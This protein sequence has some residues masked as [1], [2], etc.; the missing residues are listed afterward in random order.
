MPS[1]DRTIFALLLENALLK[2]KG[3]AFEDFF[4][5]A[6]TTLWE[7]DFSPWRSQG[8]I[9][10]FK[11]D[12]YRTSDKTVFQCYAPDNPR[13][14]A[15]SAK[16]R[17]DFGGAFIHFGEKMRRWVFV[18]NQRGGLPAT[19]E[20]LIL[21]LRDSHPEVMFESWTPDYL[22]QQILNL[23]DHQLS[24]LFPHL[25]AGQELSQATR[26]LLAK[27]AKSDAAAISGPQN[28]TNFANRLRLDEVL[29]D[30]AA[31]D[32]DLRRRLLGYSRWYDPAGKAMID[33]KLL[34]LGHTKESVENNALRLH[35]IG[36]MQVTE[37]HY[38]PLDNAICDEAAES[39]IDEFLS[40]LEQQS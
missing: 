37:N 11:C 10:D 20:M 14:S 32:Q 24:P 28:E 17:T 30:L 1:A 12:G 18:H 38:L 15:V 5:R 39:L 6:A 33:D 29:D 26:A 34:N 22:I 23:P 40:E 31:T 35:E 13:A 19:A 21:E 7:A 3:Q 2:H 25:P 9:G 27:L 4:V 16:I 36:L 8:S